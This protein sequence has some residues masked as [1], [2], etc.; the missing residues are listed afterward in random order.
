MKVLLYN[1][2]H[3]T[4]WIWKVP[5]LNALHT[6]KFNLRF[7]VKVIPRQF[8]ATT[9]SSSCFSPNAAWLLPRA[10]ALQDKPAPAW[11]LRGLQVLQGVSACSS[12]GPPWAAGEGMRQCLQRLSPPSSLTLVFTGLFPHFPPL[13]PH[14]LRSILPFIMF[15]QR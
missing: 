9:P 2:L 14:C 1:I 11:A 12:M 13:A 4:V 6:R 3:L 8:L 10:A 15:S 7:L 5:K